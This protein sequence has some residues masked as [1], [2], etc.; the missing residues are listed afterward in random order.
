MQHHA[1]RDSTESR[2]H[3]YTSGEKEE[4]SP[5]RTCAAVGIVL[6]CSQLFNKRHTNATTTTTTTT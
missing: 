3:I 1:D 6:A 2:W 4:K 5:E